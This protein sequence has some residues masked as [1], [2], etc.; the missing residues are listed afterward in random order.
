MWSSGALPKIKSPCTL[1]LHHLVLESLD[2]LPSHVAMPQLQVLY[3][4]SPSYGTKLAPSRFPNLTEINT[5]STTIGDLSNVLGH[6]VGRQLRTLRVQFVEDAQ[7]LDW[8]LDEC[9][10]LTELCLSMT[11]MRSK[12]GRLLPDTLL[13]LCLHCDKG[14]MQRGLLVQMLESAPNLVAV[15]IESGMLDVEDLVRLDELVKQGACLRHLWSLRVSHN[16]RDAYF[17]N[18][19]KRHFEQLI[20][21]CNIH[22]QELCLLDVGAYLNPWTYSY[23]IC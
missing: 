8:L 2:C 14:D 11:G 4:E 16:P 18:Q 23:E 5:C 13:T 9:P 10:N 12:G 3:L 1:Q 22:C 21:T 15:D 17:T 20:I 6:G 19:W 7:S